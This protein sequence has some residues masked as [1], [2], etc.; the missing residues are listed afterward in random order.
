[1]NLL[2][3]ECDFRILSTNDLD[4]WY[5]LNARWLNW[6]VPPPVVVVFFFFKSSNNSSPVSAC[7]EVLVHPPLSSGM[8][9][10]GFDLP[11]TLFFLASISLYLDFYT[12]CF[13]IHKMIYQL[14]HRLSETSPVQG[15]KLGQPDFNSG[16]E[17]FVLG[18]IVEHRVHWVLHH[19]QVAQARELSPFVKQV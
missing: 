10:K 18:F 8:V 2:P 19:V 17:L 5:F 4:E 9:S 6:K 16:S 13:R 3:S 11:N 1:M 15:R 14:I 12:H 7:F